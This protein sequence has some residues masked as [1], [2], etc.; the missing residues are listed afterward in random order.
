MMGH[1]W[2]WF[3]IIIVTTDHFAIIVVIVTTDHFVIVV[4]TTNHFAIIV[5]INTTD[6]FDPF[7]SPTTLLLALIG[8]F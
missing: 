1:V 7:P 5:V 3:V 2:D 8:T 4:I 6:H